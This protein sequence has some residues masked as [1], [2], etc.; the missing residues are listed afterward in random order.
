MHLRE[1]I[2]NFLKPSEEDELNQFRSTSMADIFP[3]EDEAEL[4]FPDNVSDRQ[5]EVIHIR[6]PR[7]IKE[8]LDEVRK[9]I[10]GS[11]PIDLLVEDTI[12]SSDI[13][14]K[15]L[16]IRNSQGFLMVVNLLLSQICYEYVNGK[17]GFESWT[18][19]L[20]SITVSFFQILIIILYLGS[21][22][23]RGMLLKARLIINDSSNVFKEYGIAKITISVF[24]LLFHPLIFTFNVRVTFIEERYYVSPYIYETFN[25]M[26]VDYFI[27]IHFIVNYSILIVI[28]L[29]NTMYLNN[30]S[31]R[32]A[33]IFGIE[34][35][36]IYC[37]KS[38]MTKYHIMFTMG[39]IFI[40]VLFF[41]VVIRLTESYY[42]N[43]LPVEPGQVK[44][45]DIFNT[46]FNSFWYCVVT[47]TTVGFGDIYARCLL[48]R[49]FVYFQGLYGITNSS[50][51]VISF[52][53]YFSMTMLEDNCFTLIKRIDFGEQKRQLASSSIANIW[54]YYK[55]KK[56]GLREK[57]KHFYEKGEKFLLRFED[58]KNN[59]KN[60]LSENSK[61]EFLAYSAE[62][63]LIKLENT[64]EKINSQFNFNGKSKLEER[65]D[66]N[67]EEPQVELNSQGK[68]KW[69]F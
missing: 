51:F 24:F 4:D 68:V 14:I 65:I 49:F 52:T 61:Y 27:I 63:I 48:S 23:V 16:M 42:V 10:G 60:T 19:D 35:N 40:G 46:Y 30:R 43:N 7:N 32:I 22:Q 67:A 29:E 69:E 45:Y 5:E 37:L 21:I 59:H 28:I 47:M 11:E 20:V 50:L 9:K 3:E 33:H 54:M 8:V 18:R 53:S 13:F 17:S 56:A 31:N 64:R 58:M 15:Y 55:N 2:L 44:I 41:T 57:A 39:C 36:L 38:L 66:H 6:K 26:L 34:V 12:Y 1:S 25:R 62:K